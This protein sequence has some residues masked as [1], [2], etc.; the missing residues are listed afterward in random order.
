MKKGLSASS[1]ATAPAHRAQS[2]PVD[3][4]LAAQVRWRICQQDEKY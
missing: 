3:F 2:M 4:R 1:S